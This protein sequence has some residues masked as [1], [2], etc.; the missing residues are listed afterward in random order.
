MRARKLLAASLALSAG[1]LGVAGC[2]QGGSGGEGGGKVTMTFWNNATTGDGKAF[3]EKTVA[4]F[5][6]T[7]A[8]SRPR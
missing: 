7:Q 3:W 2:G 1:V 4:D 8:S 6:A 5:Q